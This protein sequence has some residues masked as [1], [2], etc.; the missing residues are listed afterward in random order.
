MTKKSGKIVKCVWCGKSLYKIPSRVRKFNFCTPEH[1]RTFLA[2]PKNKTLSKGWKHSE[3]AKQKIKLANLS[4]NYD[5]IFTK[6]TRK[7]LAESAGNKI[8]TKEARD[9]ARKSHLG[10]KLSLEQIRKIKDH[11]KYDW[12]NKSWRG[13]YSSYVAKHVWAAKHIRKTRCEY[14]DSGF[15]PCNG[16]LQLANIDHKY[17][18]RIKDWKVLCKFHHDLYDY[19]HGLRKLTSKTKRMY[20][21]FD[22][23]QL[24]DFTVDGIIV[25][26]T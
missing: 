25:S 21:R 26:S 5:E 7:K 8:W 1:Y 14:K 10:K 24:R 17:Y 16:K 13:R 18:K 20:V 3:D 22:P 19:R 11:A 12:R 23:L 4:R 15:G 9:N 6:E 2:S